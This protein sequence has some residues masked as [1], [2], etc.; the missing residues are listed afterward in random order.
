MASGVS[1]AAIKVASDELRIAV[2]S[3][4]LEDAAT[5]WKAFKAL[6]VMVNM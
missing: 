4:N 1:A 6:A 3:G 2:E 5:K